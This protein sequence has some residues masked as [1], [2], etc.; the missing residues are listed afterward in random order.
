MLFFVSSYYSCFSPCYV[1][2]P[3]PC[4]FFPCSIYPP[5]FSPLLFFFFSSLRSVQCFILFFHSSHSFV[6]ALLSKFPI[7]PSGSSK[8][9]LCCSRPP[10]YFPLSSSCLLFLFFCEMFGTAALPAGFLSQRIIIIILIIIGVAT[11]QSPIGKLF[12]K[13]CCMLGKFCDTQLASLARLTRRCD[14]RIGIHS[15]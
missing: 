11:H 15:R 5:E 4:S 1:L 6:P 7:S 12:Q 8:S 3:F 10:S 9:H 13:C 14:A 2:S